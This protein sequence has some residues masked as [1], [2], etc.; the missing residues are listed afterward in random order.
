MANAKRPEPPDLR[1]KD[2]ETGAVRPADD[3]YLSDADKKKRDDYVAKVAKADA[4][5]QAK[6]AK[7]RAEAASQ[8]PITDV[9]QSAVDQAIE[10]P[11]GAE[12]NG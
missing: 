9:L 8:D 12:R 11:K 2:P 7:A 6:V 4:A 3:R 10:P 5:D 1:P